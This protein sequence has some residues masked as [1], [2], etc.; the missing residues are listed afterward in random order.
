MFLYV[1]DEFDAGQIAGKLIS[2]ADSLHDDVVF[3]Q[4]LNE[5]KKEVAKEVSG[6][7]R[8]IAVLKICHYVL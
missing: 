2:I 8:L 1:S 6:P 7:I 3:R 5:F 4:A